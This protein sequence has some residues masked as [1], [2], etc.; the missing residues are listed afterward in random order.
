VTRVHRARGVLLIVMISDPNDQ[1]QGLPGFERVFRA[2]KGA[3]RAPTAGEFTPTASKKPNSER[4]R[5]PI[6]A[7]RVGRLFV[8][9][10][11]MFMVASFVLYVGLSLYSSF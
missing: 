2:V 10:W 5:D 3:D 7:R 6:S 9:V 1:D 4:D 11:I 8:I